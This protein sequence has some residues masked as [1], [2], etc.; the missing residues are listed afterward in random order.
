MDQSNFFE[1]VLFLTSSQNDQSEDT[2]ILGPKDLELPSSTFKRTIGK[3]VLFDASSVELMANKVLSQVEEVETQKMSEE[4]MVR[5]IREELK[6]ELLED[7][8]NANIVNLLNQCKE[9]LTLMQGLSDLFSLSTS[10]CSGDVKADLNALVQSLEDT[11]ERI[12]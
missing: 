8:E 1:T 6:E 9:K 11:L 3:K 4:E 2:I 10:S 7:I 12:S 5:T